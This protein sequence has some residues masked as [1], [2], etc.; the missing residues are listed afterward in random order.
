M[1]ESSGLG[2]SREIAGLGWLSM[3]QSGVSILR[4]NSH[5]RKKKR[6]SI[7]YAFVLRYSNQN[8]EILFESLLNYFARNIPDDLL[9]HLA[10]LED[11]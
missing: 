7:G 9:F 2:E 6:R 3:A 8:S 5:S 11:Q 4:V 10:A 1:K